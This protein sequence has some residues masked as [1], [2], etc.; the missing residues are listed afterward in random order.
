[1]REDKEAPRRCDAVGGAGGKRDW[2]KVQRLVYTVN[3][4]GECYSLGWR[5]ARGG[6][7]Y[8]GR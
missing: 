1:M 4:L 6:R 5:A 3:D 7:R 8:V 2:P